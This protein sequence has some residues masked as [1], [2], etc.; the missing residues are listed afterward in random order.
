MPTS[1]HEQ[2]QE[3]RRLRAHRAERDESLYAAQL[4]LRKARAAADRGRRQETPPPDRRLGEPRHPDRRG[5]PREPDR[6][7]GAESLDELERAYTEA[8]RGLRD[9]RARLHE[10]I[11]THVPKHPHDVLSNLPDDVPLLLLP[12]RVETR[13]AT[14]DGTPQLWVRA[15]PDDIAVH[16]H[17]KTLTD[18][19]VEAGEQ[20]WRELWPAATGADAEAL[21]KKAWGRL[22]DRFGAKRAAW[23]A[24]E[25]RPLDWDIQPR[26]AFP[27][28]PAHDL[29]KTSA[30]S[31]APRTRVLPD[32]LVVLLYQGA[33][34]VHEVE[35]A[36]IPDEL[37]LGP[38]P[39]EE[40]DSFQTLDGKLVFGEAFAWAS[41]FERSVRSGMGFR[42]PIT[43]EQAQTGFSKV[44]VL[45]VLVS[46]DADDSRRL[47]EELLDNHHYS[48]KG[49]ALVR[50]GTPTNNTDD[51]AAGF[52][53]S[54]PL[55]AMSYGVEAGSPLFTAADATDG[56]I[57]ADALG[58][59]YGPLQFV[60]NADATDQQEAV[61]MNTA[62]YPGTLGYYFDTLLAPV[63]G[64]PARDRLR[65]FFISSV[66]GRG[67]LPA[68]RVGHQP[69]GLL[70]TS[71]FGRWQWSPPETGRDSFLSVLHATLAKYHAAWLERLSQVAH[72]GR[73]GEAADPGAL[74]MD[75]LGLQAGSVAFHQR[76]AYSTDYLLNR[77]AF[78]YGGRYF[79]DVQRNFTSKGLLLT[80]LQSLGYGTPGT[81]PPVPQ[82]LRLVFQHFHTVLDARNLVDDV[83]LS[84]TEV[85]RY[86]DETAKKNYLDWLAETPTVDALERQDFGAGRPA[87]TALLYMML[88]RAL[89]L[90]LHA[91]AVKWFANRNVDV[92]PTLAATNF[93]NIRPEPS[94]TKW[95]VM[96]AKVGVGVAQHPFRD[97]A[98]SDHLLTSGRDE[99]E[100]DFLNR[101]R[102]AL[103]T[104]A[105]LPTA[106]LE[107]LLTE[108]V[109]T[110]TYRLDAWQAAMFSVRLRHQRERRK[111]GV[112]L[113]AVGWV[114]D[115]RPAARVEVPRT[116]VPPALAP[117]V[118]EP[119]FEY[120]RNGGF[121]HAPSLNHATAAAVLRSGYLAHASSAQPDAMAVNLSSE[122][123]RRAR[124]VLQGVRNGQP[125]EALLGYQFEREL[126]DVAS[127]D[128]VQ[129]RLNE[130]IYDF[131][132]AF[133]IEHH[134]LR[135][136]G[137]DGPVEAIAANN[138]VNGV[139]L[140]QAAGDVPYG[141]TG[142]VAAAS[143]AERET[144][145]QAKT[146]LADTLDAV[147]DLLLSEGVYQMVLGNA[148]RAGAV[149]TAMKDTNVPPEIDVV[150]TPRG[151]RFSFTNRLTLQFGPLDPDLP[152]SN[153]WTGV[154]MTP[155][156][157]TEPGLNQWLGRILGDPT[158]LVCRVS[159]LD[160]DG[161][162]ADSAEVDVQQLALQPI[163]LVYLVGQELNTGAGTNGG[164]NRTSASALEARIAWRY[165]ELKGLADD[166]RIRI[167]FLKPAGARTLG[168]HLLLLRM[169]RSLVT[170]SRELH[171]VDFTPPSKPSAA[172][173]ANPEGYDAG[174]LTTR[175]QTEAVAAADALRGSIGLVPIDAV[176][177][178]ADGVDHHVTTLQETF[179]ALVAAKLTFRDVAVTF[180]D[181]HATQLQGH[182][183]SA[184]TLG[185]PD[186]FPVARV[187]TDA[188]KVALLEQAQS[189]TRRL[190]AAVARATALLAQAA[191]ETG[192]A[193]R[194][195]LLI[196]AGQAVLDGSF[197]ILPRFRY[198]NEID[199]QA[200]HADRAQLLEHATTALAMRYPADE[201]VQNVS[202]VRPRTARW[203][204][205]LSLHEVL[206]GERL[207]LLPV[208]LPFRSQDSWLAV[209][210]PADDPHQPGQ[211]FTITHDTVSVTIHGAAA[212]APATSHCGLLI[213][214]WT[215]LI[216]TR[217]EITGITF[218]YDQ[219]S[220]APPQALLLAVTPQPKGQWTWADLVGIV[221]DT[222]LRA[223]LRAV[224]PRLL[225]TL[226]RPDV[227]VLL[228]AVLADFSQL[229]LNLALDF[230]LNIKQVAQ[231]AAIQSVARTME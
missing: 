146:R 79:E 33:D 167:E 87:P 73:P 99:G 2:L 170:G 198:S 186:A 136:Q 15:Y 203:D 199:I 206:A 166:V 86:H 70:L 212:F 93:Y 114:E 126:H 214:E 83:P 173:P 65:E 211:P 142:S 89:L 68:L 97:R 185:L 132:A 45:G 38:D 1:W 84:E 109:D 40:D 223:K 195:R 153:P 194:V 120:V 181:A 77:D 188:S 3:I 229:D 152:A 172:D 74:L 171:A 36:P 118:G 180:T 24:G 22:A 230:R 66:S 17:E 27:N 62:M 183:R 219:S 50:Q 216:P 231:T 135:Q 175:I 196:A 11:A 220:A 105:D 14:V 189:V 92:S 91:A 187:L 165:R 41:D 115:L 159:H 141:A 81:P 85:V 228:P 25:T 210:F 213:D 16:T 131:R 49:L 51:G 154:A 13:F 106:R 21:R 75:V 5:E 157:R 78:Q 156:A 182:L 227:N 18:Q 111:A 6:R 222:L 90:Q 207:Q 133:P 9:A 134:H 104:L 107:R 208:Q 215:E 205:I 138:V 151:S 39:L 76:T 53:T 209:E 179:D 110:C 26:P 197:T 123:I 12:L 127:A 63:L 192:V 155:R 29:T 82:L 163:D 64:E 71:D 30:W 95:E 225:D 8:K 98:I 57:L 117:P 125:L 190:A 59:G 130:Y 191:T 204:A 158:T 143:A 139:R 226:D 44:L 164:E 34:V 37:F 112:F 224:E 31:R 162:E 61:A 176:V 218:H 150:D 160:A 100:A 137:S 129:I 80:F 19:E 168:K 119:V 174:E 56:R 149:M 147:K 35:G 116:Q 193:A 113:G 161:D 122:R 177:T 103:R 200:S 140:G 69:Y 88:R 4:R 55:N 42:I 58:I 121:V 52:T 94:L 124:S 201:W 46:A 32:K 20:Y 178:D 145:R 28:F 144:I 72:V 60:A 7:R 67:P 54:D 202:H 184:A 48:P 102:A 23:I 10:A 108:H 221:N 96:R 47:L 148:D 217:S 169:L 43:A 101:V 128:A